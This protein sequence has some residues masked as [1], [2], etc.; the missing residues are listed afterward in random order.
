MVLNQIRDSKKQLITGLVE[1]AVVILVTGV[2]L[3][4]VF[5]IW[6]LKL[7]IP[8]LQYSWDALFSAYSFKA[9]ID[10]G[11]VYS[12]PYI[13]APYG[14]NLLDFPGSDSLHY[15]L[16]FIISLVTSKTFTVYNLYYYL[17]F[18][19]TSVSSFYV[20][21]KLKINFIIALP[22]A[23]AYSFLPYH[24][25]RYEHIYLA[26]YFMLPLCLWL[27]YAI[28][29]G[30]WHILNKKEG[31]RKNSYS[32]EKSKIA[33]I[34]LICLF[35]ASSGIYY[36]VFMIM[37]GFFAW[38]YYLI[39]ERE[40]RSRQKSVNMGLVALL[41]FTITLANLAPSIIY[42]SVNGP[43]STPV[44]ERLWTEADTHGLK[45]AS[46]LLPSPLHRIRSLRDITTRYNESALLVFDTKAAP[47]GLLGV[48]GLTI[49]IWFLLFGTEHNHPLKKFGVINLLCIFIAT[50]G[51]FGSMFAFLVNPSLRAF[52][53]ISVVI[54]FVSLAAFALLVNS[55][56]NSKRL[57]GKP[58]V[59]GL[60]LA[61]LLFVVW[62]D[63]AYF[64]DFQEMY[65]DHTLRYLADV[66]YARQIEEK[67]QKG[68]HVFQLPYMQFPENGQLN[69]MFDYDH[70]RP[71]LYSTGLHWSYGGVKGR[72]SA[73]FA[74]ETSQLPADQ[75]VKA[76]K[77]E[78]FSA[79]S[80][81]RRGYQDNGTSI[82][83]ALKI[84][85]GADPIYSYDQRYLFF[86]I[87]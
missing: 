8:L 1:Y 74:E 37:V 49:S 18:F 84:A 21:R 72:A 77:E 64:P 15:A 2:F 55:F 58:V 40:Q 53:R 68:A 23:V 41:I 61:L 81:D 14:S 59:S 48:L 71:Y 44:A 60:I 13:G 78:G 26:S 83:A 63:Q 79:I 75:M 38:F 65:Q 16:A 20:L 82:E 87:K 54:G 33:P 50:V 36:S 86:L 27:Y 85:L 32:I 30:E 7:Q 3:V 6:K 62:F 22:V 67:V 5:P 76:L 47:L 4:S 43:P 35:T 25:L 42:R 39:S 31:S 70:F 46:L 29:T 9:I 24:F 56:V 11:W 28:S 12:N 80:I 19:L 52:S 73:I 57:T 69:G 51:G 17:G 45:I 10:N 34:L 66:Q